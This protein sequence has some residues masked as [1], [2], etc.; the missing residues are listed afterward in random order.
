MINA[1]EPELLYLRRSHPSEL[2]E[3][4][5]S[6]GGKLPTIVYILRPEMLAHLAIDATKFAL[7]KK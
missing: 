2:T 7:T 5:V 4:V 6:Y 1:I 3:L